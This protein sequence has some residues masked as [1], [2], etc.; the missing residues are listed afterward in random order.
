L[1]GYYS[2]DYIDAHFYQNIDLDLIFAN[3]FTAAQITSNYYEKGTVDDYIDAKIDAS[4][5]L[6]MIYNEGGHNHLVAIDPTTDT[7]DL[8]IINKQTNQKF[9]KF[10]IHGTTFFNDVRANNMIFV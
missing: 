9:V 8:D 10:D 7:T 4:Y 1:F 3:Y 6:D 5:V 2:K